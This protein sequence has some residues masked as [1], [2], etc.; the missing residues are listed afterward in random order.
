MET[1][2]GDAAAETRIFRLD[3][4]LKYAGGFGA[5]KA[6]DISAK[7]RGARDPMYIVQSV[8]A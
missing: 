8:K 5:P 2:R 6:Y 4:Y 7:G 1:S 3:R